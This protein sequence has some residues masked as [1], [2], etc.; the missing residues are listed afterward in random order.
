L[1]EE[2]LRQTVLERLKEY[3]YNPRAVV[4]VREYRSRRV[5]VLGAVVKP[6]LYSLTSGADTLLDTIAQAGGIAA[7]AEPRIYLIPAEPATGNGANELASLLPE[8][9]LQQDPAP[10]I[11]KKADPILIDVKELSFGGSQRYL[12]LAVRPG[13]V[14]MVPGGGYV[15]VEGWV[16]KPGAYSFSP[17][18]SITGA[19]AQAGG[20]LFPADLNAIKVIR[21]EKKGSKS[22]IVA[23]VEKIKRGEAAD[24]PL[25]GGDIVQVSAQ[26]SKLIPY[27]LYRFFSS[28]IN[29]GVGGTVPIVH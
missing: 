16:D 9:L 12:S 26:T 6:G 23:D 7:G 10:L 4:F 1:T 25:Q 28:V 20:Q 3:M 5:A 8:T 19:I 14:I 18:L 21:A 13:D 22:F 27:G 2:Q 17:G 15:L 29:V 24:I 11:L